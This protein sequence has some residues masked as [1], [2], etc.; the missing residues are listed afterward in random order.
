MNKPNMVTFSTACY[1]AMPYMHRA[2]LDDRYRQCADEIRLFI[3]ECFE[4]TIEQVDKEIEFW[5]DMS[6]V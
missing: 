5:E 4:R 3:A 6:H 1:K 2:Q